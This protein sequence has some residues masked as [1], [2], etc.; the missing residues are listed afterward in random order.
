MGEWCLT[1]VVLLSVIAV[2][3]IKA[4]KLSKRQL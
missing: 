2:L 1:G 3:P 4:A